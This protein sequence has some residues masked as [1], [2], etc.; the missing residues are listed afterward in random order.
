[1]I[2]LGQLPLIRAPRG[3]AAEMVARKL[4]ARLRDHL[5]TGRNS[6]LFSAG[7]DNSFGRPR[8][9]FSLSSLIRRD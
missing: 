7:S 1:M 4:D 2:N 3:N 8:E 6:N 5:A 9:C